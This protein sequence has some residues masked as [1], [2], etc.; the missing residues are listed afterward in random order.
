MILLDILNKKIKLFS[1]NEK[2]KNILASLIIGYVLT[3][4]SYNEN[5]NKTLNIETPSN[6]P[7]PFT[8]KNN[9][10]NTCLCNHINK[11]T[12]PLTLLISGL[13][14]K[15]NFYS[16]ELN[17]FCKTTCLNSNST[18]SFERKIN[19]S[20]DIKNKK[21]EN[22]NIQKRGFSTLSRSNILKRKLSTLARSSNSNEQLNK[23]FIKNKNINYNKSIF[24]ILEKIKEL[25]ENKKY[26]PNEVQLKIENFWNDILKDKYS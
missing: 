4:K 25:T 10:E 8:S 12:N 19:D 14:I 18:L 11:T 26:N 13:E 3:I 20:V 5:S 9:N 24:S 17:N 15:N 7:Y 21:S 22:V 2:F 6:F 23:S 16:S 1:S